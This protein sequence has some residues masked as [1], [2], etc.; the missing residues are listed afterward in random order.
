MKI[1]PLMSLSESETHL[2]TFISSACQPAG[3]ADVAKQVT[4]AQSSQA[5]VT[6]RGP[7]LETDGAGLALPLVGFSLFGGRCSSFSFSI[8]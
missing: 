1:R 4:T 2:R 6:G 7:G 3:N 5:V 8:H